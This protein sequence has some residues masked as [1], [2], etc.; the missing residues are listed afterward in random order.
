MKFRPFLLTLVLLVAGLVMLNS[1]TKKYICHCS[2]QYSGTPG[3]PDST[4]Q[5]YDIID[6]KAGATAKCKAESKTADNNGIHTVENCYL[7]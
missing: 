4:F 3:L 5:E 6:N 1:C 7:Y 2:I